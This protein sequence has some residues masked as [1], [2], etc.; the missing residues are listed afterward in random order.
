MLLH[1]F[2]Y[3]HLPSMQSLTS[4][5]F[6]NFTDSHSPF[7]DQRFITY[8][9]PPPKSP[10]FYFI[11]FFSFQFNPVYPP[12]FPL[13]K[14]LSCV[15]LPHTRT[16]VSTA[17]VLVLASI[18]TIFIYIELTLLPWKWMQYVFLKNW[19][20]STKPCDRTRQYVCIVTSMKISNLTWNLFHYNTLITT[21]AKY[22]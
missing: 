4:A 21:S 19:H 7:Q 20:L 9:I 11:F 13:I 6:L 8:F 12:S 16:G 3:Y 17:M 15:K 2:S 5:S 14:H 18:R 1:Y 10:S 22:I